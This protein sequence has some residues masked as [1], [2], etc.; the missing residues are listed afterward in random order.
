M[1][2]ADAVDCLVMGEGITVYLPVGAANATVVAIFF[3]D[4]GE[5]DQSPQV[6]IVANMCLFNSCRALEQL[7]FFLTGCFK[8]RYNLFERQLPVI[9]HLT[10][11]FIHQCRCFH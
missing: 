11:S 1:R 8:V 2:E 3:T 10:H 7:I 5:F 6:D 4:V 9:V